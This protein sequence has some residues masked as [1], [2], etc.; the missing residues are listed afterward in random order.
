MSDSPTGPELLGAINYVRDFYRNVAALLC[1]ADDPLARRGYSWTGKSWKPIP[2]PEQSLMR[3][4]TWL[5]QWV[6]RQYRGGK[7][8]EDVLTVAVLAF[9]A[10]DGEWTEPWCLASRLVAKVTPDPV[11]WVS[12]LQCRTLAGL[13]ETPSAVRVTRG[14][15]QPREERFR[16]FDTIVGEAGEIISIAVPLVQICNAKDLETRVLEPVL[17]EKFRAG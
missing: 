10:I 1:A 8:P 7:V 15:L 4:D 2:W 12:L 6:I 5:P 16:D 3:A 13:K 11:Y 17:R 14:L 9:D